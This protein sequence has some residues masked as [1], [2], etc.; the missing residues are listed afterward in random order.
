MRNENFN[1]SILKFFDVE[2]KMNLAEKYMS[3]IDR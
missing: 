2:W 1:K 3:I